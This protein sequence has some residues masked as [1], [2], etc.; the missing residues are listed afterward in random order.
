MKI[1]ERDLGRVLEAVT[2]RRHYRALSRM[3]ALYPNFPDM[4]GRYALATGTYPAEAKVRT[5][6][7]SVTAQLFSRHDVLTVNEVF[8]REDYPATPET[9]VVVDFGSN[10][11]ITALYFLTRNDFSRCYL[12]EPVPRNIERLR[13][14]LRGFEARYALATVAVAPTAG[15]VTFGVEESGR[16]GGIGVPTTANIRVTCRNVN[17]V[18]G[19]IIERE[20]VVDILKIDTEGME[21][22]IVRAIE[23]RHL[24]RIRNIYAE[25]PDDGKELPALEGFARQRYGDVLQF[26]NRMSVRPG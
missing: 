9:R 26:S 8:C 1:G 20:G 16:Y 3:V 11:G 5:P 2:Q 14:N 24:A 15:E 13:E 22:P 7:G 25:I 10:I 4:F 21:A 12:F 6:N 18:L 23:P 19:E 17:D